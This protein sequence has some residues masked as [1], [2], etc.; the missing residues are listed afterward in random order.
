MGNI[1]IPA[2]EDVEFKAQYKK[3]RKLKLCS[4]K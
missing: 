3:E 1:L 4:L 2:F